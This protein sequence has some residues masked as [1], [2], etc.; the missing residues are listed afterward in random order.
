MALVAI[1]TVGRLH[2][3]YDHPVSR[4]FFEKGYKAF[5]S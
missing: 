3:P 2:H 1:Y 5:S 4:D